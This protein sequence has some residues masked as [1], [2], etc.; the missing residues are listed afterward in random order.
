MTQQD[1]AA[2][3]LPDR[4]L[5][6][7]VGT[8]PAQNRLIRANRWLRRSDLPFVI[9]IGICAGVALSDVI[10]GV[11][12]GT[13]RQV[14]GGLALLG[15]G[16]PILFLALIGGRERARAV[17][18]LKNAEARLRDMVEVSS[19]WLWETGPDLRFTH[20]AG[21]IPGASDDKNE[22]VIGKTR[23]EIGDLT[24]DPAGWERH[25]HDLANRRP[26]RDFVYRQRLNNGAARWRKVSGK[27]FY[28]ADGRFLG[29]RGSAT[30]VTEQKDAE[31]ALSRALDDARQ[32]EAKYR[33]LVAN[34]PGAVYRTLL[35]PARS[36]VY[37]SA[38]IEAITGY[39]AAEYVAGIAPAW[40]ETIDADD[41][42]RASRVIGEAIAAGG[43]FA[44]EYRVRHRDGS[45]RWV[46]DRGQTIVGEGG[47]GLYCDGLMFD[48]TDR[49]LVEADL[50]EAK[51]QAEGASRAKSD[52]LA[53]MSHEL[54]TPL[55]AIIGFAEMLEDQAL[56]PIGNARYRDY[57][58]DIGASGKHLLSLINDIL[59]LS[60][61]EAGAMEL[62]EEPVDIASVIESC[63]AMVRPRTEQAR[64]TVTVDIA[65]GLP[66]LSADERKLRQAVLNLLSNSVKYSAVGG[67]IHVSAAATDEGLRVCV[68]DNGIGIAA[69][70]I[71]KALSPFGQV[72][73]PLNRRTTG[74]GLGLPLAKRI[75]E[76]HGGR[77]HIAS[78]VGKGT[79]V[80]LDMPA[81]R[82]IRPAT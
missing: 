2:A 81:H 11:A 23:F 49:K 21:H 6:G 51:E 70:D 36:I 52:F 64:I 54:R 29:Y 71:S 76:V 69:A 66:L 56:G 74:T 5:P 67:E 3:T 31:E 42:E 78:E 1:P 8:A 35:D 7:T 62:Y 43:S 53:I 65:A 18:D 10:E 25:A 75:I 46:F 48:I 57:A 40:I 60:K 4:P 15:I 77:F 79:T 80:T 72:D 45:V 17:N 9:A 26:F 22:S 37:I 58:E 13:L 59:D 20:F 32:S 33:S 50:R 24:I 73:S 44:V 63:I 19:D 61:A 14:I 82:L 68:A 27:P 34:V 12:A 39:R 55:N 16:V 28:G 38:P 30:D 41:R 47:R